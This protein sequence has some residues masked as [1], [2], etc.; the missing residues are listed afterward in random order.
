MFGMTG[1]LVM[2]IFGWGT[3]MWSICATPIICLPYY[4]KILTLLVL[5][6]CGWVGYEMS[7]FA[8][9]DN[10]F[11]I[12]FYAASSFAGSLWFMPFFSTYCVF[13]LPLGV[14]YRAKRVFDSG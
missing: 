11:S 5:F 1:L 10:L 2:Y 14:G 4:L 3:V 9:S 7:G 8:C 6:M 13:F 12:H